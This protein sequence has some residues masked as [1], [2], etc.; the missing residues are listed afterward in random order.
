MHKRKKKRKKRK[1]NEIKTS[2]FLFLFKKI[3]KTIK[4]TQLNIFTN[5]PSYD[6]FEMIFVSFFLTEKKRKK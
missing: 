1:K 5:Q 6:T 4:E 3:Y 2:F